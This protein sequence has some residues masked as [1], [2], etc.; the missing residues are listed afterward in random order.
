M[1]LYT[2]INLKRRMGK[3]KN[4]E[5]YYEPLDEEIA[6]V[7]IGDL[8]ILVPEHPFWA[9]FAKG[10]EPDTERIYRENVKQGSVIL[11]VG[12]WIGPTL[13]FGLY[14]GASSIVALEPN[15]TSFARLQKLVALNPDFNARITL[16]NRAL[17][18]RPGKLDMGQIRGEEDTSMFSISGNGVEVETISLFSLIDD[19]RLDQIDLIKIDIEGAEALLLDELQALSD[20]A[21]QVIHLSVHVPMFPETSDIE[22]MARVLSAFSVT[23]DR[24]DR[25]QPEELHAR[26]TTKERFPEWGTQHGNFFELLLV[27]R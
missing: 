15:P 14:C 18:S 13:I 17:H 24:G 2:L 11:D 12:A 9:R 20:R 4:A 16:I 25:L 23:D 8:E 26:L 22:R 6:R 19:Y 3:M 27:A 21:G 10:W 5:R 1:N 7:S